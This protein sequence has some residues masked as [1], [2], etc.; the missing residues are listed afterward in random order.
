MFWKALQNEKLTISSKSLATTSDQEVGQKN[1][2]PEKP[3]QIVYPDAS[4]QELL[5]D[6]ENL[7]FLNNI[8][9]EVRFLLQFNNN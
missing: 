7:K 2:W 6:E 3:L 5:I 1:P 8:Q 9:D 4:H